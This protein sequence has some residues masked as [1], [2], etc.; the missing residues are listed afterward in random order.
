MRG[1]SDRGKVRDKEDKLV[2]SRTYNLA[3]VNLIERIRRR[4]TAL[5]NVISGCEVFTWPV[6]INAQTNEEAAFLSSLIGL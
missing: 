3:S 1:R 4:E 5:C 6:N 2:R